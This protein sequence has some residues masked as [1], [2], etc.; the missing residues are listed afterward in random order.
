M[1]IAEDDLLNKYISFNKPV[2]YKSFLIYPIRLCD[3]YDVQ[4]ILNLL[5]V[6]KNILG[7]IELI[8]MSNLRFILMT[9]YVED[10]YRIQLDCLLRKA[11]D[12]SN[13][14]EI[15]IYVDD[16]SEEILIGEKLTEIHGHIILD[17]K[18]VQKINADD[19]NEIKRIILYQN[20]IDYTDKYIDP[21]VKKA[22][23]EYYRLKSKDAIHVSLEHK[24]ICVQLKTGMSLEE[25]G[26][27][28]MRNFHLLFNVIVD[29]SDYMALKFAELNGVKF[30]SSIE[31][32]A[33]RATKDKYAEAFCDADAFT[34]K[35][36]SIN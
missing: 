18:T 4:D 31:N 35:V 7:N 27:L 5:Q 11:L 23:E 26:N 20:I 24:M 1:H 8:S 9:A 6:D 19:F 13:N 30:K 16:N 34:D 10:I 33:Y 28:T 22:T 36:R 21:D 3:T 2:P 25:I 14:K 15:Q 32:W 29:E 17:E 12:I